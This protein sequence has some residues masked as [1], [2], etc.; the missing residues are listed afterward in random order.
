MGSI[1]ISSVFF[2]GSPRNEAGPV[3]ER[4]APTF[5][6]AQA[7]PAAAAPATQ[8]ATTAAIRMDIVMIVPPE[9][10]GAQVE[11]NMVQMTPAGPRVPRPSRH[12]A[13]ALQH[14]FPQPLL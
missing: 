10:V 5:T 11:A 7:W 14:R 6:C 9:G 2:S 3:T 1:Y 13:A 12:R 4:T 8:A